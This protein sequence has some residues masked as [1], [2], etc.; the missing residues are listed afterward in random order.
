MRGQ[1]QFFW[2]LFLGA[3]FGCFFCRC[4]ITREEHA[5]RHLTTWD[6]VGGNCTGAWGA[7]ASEQ[8]Q[9]VGVKGWKQAGVCLLLSVKKS[10]TLTETRATEQPTSYK[11]APKAVHHH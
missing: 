1:R 4:R 2:V 10:R 9:S 8:R 3:F 11:G 5:Q 7:R 6:G